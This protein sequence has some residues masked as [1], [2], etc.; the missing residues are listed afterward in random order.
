MA[1]RI[2]NAADSSLLVADLVADLLELFDKSAWK[3]NG[4]GYPTGVGAGGTVTQLTSKSTAVTL[5]T[6]SGQITMN[7]ASLAAGAVVA[8]VLNN[9][10]ISGLDTLSINLVNTVVN[11]VNYRVWAATDTAAAAI[12]VENRSAG[13]LAEAVV[14]KFNVV[15]GANN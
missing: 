3:D 6:V 7:A 5:N 14:L 10:K 1:Q 9:S 12:Y 13:A 11:P 4:I 15:K 8:F 2:N